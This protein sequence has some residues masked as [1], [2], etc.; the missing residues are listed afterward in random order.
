LT[1]SEGLENPSTFSSTTLPVSPSRFSNKKAYSQ[2]FAATM[3]IR[4][5]GA[6]SGILAA[7]LLGQTGRGELAVIVFMPMMLIS[8]GEFEL[9]RSLIVESGKSSSESSELVSTAFWLAL[10]LGSL[11]MVLLALVLPLFLPPDKLHLLASARL[12]ALYL[13]AT[14][15]TVALTGIDQGRGRFGRFSF[16]Q[17]LPGIL[18][19]SA[20]TCI[21]WP[22]HHISPGTFAFATLIA[23]VFT[24]LLRV[25][26]DWKGIVIS[27][28]SLSMA[29][30]LL[31]RGF[32][33]YIPTLAGLA[34]LRADMFLLVRLAPE[35]AIGAYAVAQAISMGQVG[36]INPFVQVGF[37]AVARQTGH[38]D[39]LQTLARHFRLAQIAAIGMGALAV[40]F[41]P[42][43]IRVFFGVQFLT[44]TTATY[45]LIGAAAFWGM[46]ETLEQ[47]LRAASHPNLGIISN[48]LGLAIV[49]AI[50]VPA[51]MRFGIGGLA[52]IVFLGQAVSLFALIG[53]CVFYLHM[54]AGLFWA[55]GAKTFHELRE[56]TFSLFKRVRH[57]SPSV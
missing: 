28:P 36:V 23:V 26:Q 38:A 21:I 13:P 27:H 34:L 31:R 30:R 56:I 2:T 54:E 50:G 24:A 44:A 42:W 12:F 48:L 29:S 9:S 45:F 52:A 25:A 55:F 53:F 20:I 1:T 4:V 19:L 32:T 16:F 7:R 6:L 14:Y 37:A 57:A 5:F 11:E 51:C 49:L 17:V 39:A 15:I 33:F 35:A 3:A 43:G 18:Y 40:A 10:I 22:T 47:G 46:G 8:L 41:T